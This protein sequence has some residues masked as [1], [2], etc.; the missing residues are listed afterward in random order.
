[1]PKDQL[2]T[3]KLHFYA[4]LRAH[5]C[6]KITVTQSIKK[7]AIVLFFLFVFLVYCI[8]NA[9]MFESFFRADSLTLSNIIGYATQN[10]S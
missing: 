9:K 10:Q 8:Q 1:M 3:C 6:G 2:T 5:P 7:V 4:L